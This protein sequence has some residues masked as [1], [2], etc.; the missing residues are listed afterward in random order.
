MRRMGER[1]VPG[2]RYGHRNGVY[3][4]ALVGDGV[5]L[6]VQFDPG[7]EFQLPGGGEEPGEQ[8]L[9]ALH[10][11]VME[12]TGWGI[13]GPRRIGGYRRFAYMPDYDRWAEKVCTL[14]LARAVRRRAPPVEPGHMDVIVPLAEAADLVA[15]DGER[16]HLRRIAALQA[17]A[18]VPSY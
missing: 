6:T 18:S 15:T 2:Q 5:L 1:I 3:A 9:Q 10:R 12:E 14:Y 7:P 8:P 4:I 13:A 17:I 11:E 16:H